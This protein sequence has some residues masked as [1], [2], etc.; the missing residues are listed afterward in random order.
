MTGQEIIELISRGGFVV[1]LILVILAGARG[2]WVYGWAWKRERELNDHLA[3]SLDRL[4][5]SFE[6][7]VELTGRDRHA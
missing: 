5:R 7:L 3:D 1:A 6:A 2:Y 4:S